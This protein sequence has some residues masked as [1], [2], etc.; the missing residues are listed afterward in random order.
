MIK[1]LPRQLGHW[2]PVQIHRSE[3]N[4]QNLRSCIKTID[5]YVCIREDTGDLSICP[6][7]GWPLHFSASLDFVGKSLKYICFS[8]TKAMS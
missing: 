2:R 7:S 5:L 6:G 1:L 3:R 4:P 8:L